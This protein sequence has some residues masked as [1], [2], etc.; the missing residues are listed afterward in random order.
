[1]IQI[2]DAWAIVFVEAVVIVATLA[3]AHQVSGGRLWGWLRHRFA[4][5]KNR[6][7]LIMVLLLPSVA[8]ACFGVDAVGPNPAAN[9]TVRLL[10]GFIT[11]LATGT[12]LLLRRQRIDRQNRCQ[13]YQKQIEALKGSADPSASRT[14]KHLISA[15]NHCGETSVD[16]TCCRLQ[17]ADLSRTKLYGARM[18]GAD[19]RG[20]DLQGVGLTG[21][22]LRGARL[23]ASDFRD[24][25]LYRANLRDVDLSQADLRGA[26]LRE[27]DLRGARLDG[28]LLANARLEEAKLGGASFRAARLKNT[29]V[30]VAQLL[31]T[32]SLAHARLDPSLHAELVSARY[33]LPH[34]ARRLLRLDGTVPLPKKVSTLS[35]HP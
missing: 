20:A 19:L 8:V 4:A 11:V 3:A 10:S 32:Q 28:C 5:G 6:S 35:L 30:T 33:P 1:M 12:F 29:Q 9:W 15:L 13:G 25:F 31:K 26:D 34:P 24:A 23:A 17:G 2:Y 21:A 7:P 18:R 22:D 16:L 14:I 27:A